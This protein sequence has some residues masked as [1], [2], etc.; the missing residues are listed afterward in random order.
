[1]LRHDNAILLLT[2]RDAAQKSLA[3]LKK[4]GVFSK[5]EFSSDEKDYV[6]FFVSDALANAACENLFGLK[7]P[8]T[9]KTLSNELGVAAS[10]WP[11]AGVHLILTAQGHAA[12]SDWLQQQNSVTQ[13]R[14]E[15]YEALCIQAGIP[16]ISAELINEY[17]PQMFN[18]QAL[19]GIDFDKG[20][21]MGQEVIARTKF[22]GKN[23]RA[24]YTFSIP[25]N[26]G[27]KVADEVEKKLG[28]NWRRGG[29]VIRCANLGDESYFMAVLAND[30]QADDV[31]RLLAHP[32]VEV[33]AMT[34]PYSVEPEVR[35]PLKSGAKR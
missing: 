32:T 3:E 31:F 4:Y 30:T 12:F 25:G 1:M 15:V 35:S 21:Y 10:S 22:L 11:A 23:K 18:L 27:V 5:V 6:Q 29:K 24:A 26:I 28:D 8:A 9:G 13:Y 7:A 14:D 34:L 20:C 19:N 2:N 16:D 17:V 33:N